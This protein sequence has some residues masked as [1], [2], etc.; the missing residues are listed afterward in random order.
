M[1]DAEAVPPIPVQDAPSASESYAPPPD[2]EEGSIPTDDAEAAALA[3][4]R[5]RGETLAPAAP[6]TQPEAESEL[7]EKHNAAPS[8]EELRQKIP[9]EVLDALEDLFRARWQRVIRVR[10]KDL[11]ESK[12]ANNA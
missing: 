2:L 5:E 4:A 1:E 6:A 10:K 11:A 8:L 9:A 12:Q 7:E 3:D